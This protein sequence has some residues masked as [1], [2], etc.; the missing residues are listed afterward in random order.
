MSLTYTNASGNKRV[1]IQEIIG[2]PVLRRKLMVDCIIATQ[3]REGIVTTKEQA[4][5]AYDKV[6]AEKNISSGR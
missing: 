6:L 1:N 5:A 3:A 2:N 4:E